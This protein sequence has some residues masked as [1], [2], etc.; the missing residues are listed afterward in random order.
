VAD[1]EEQ[2]GHVQRKKNRSQAE[3]ELPQACR[4]ELAA[5]RADM[6]VAD[7][8]LTDMPQRHRPP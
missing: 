7:R 5:A 6:P 3:T 8:W 4:K 2:A 1:G